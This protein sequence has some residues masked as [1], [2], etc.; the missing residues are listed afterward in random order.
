[1]LTPCADVS[2][3]CLVY[4]IE[5]ER[6]KATTMSGSEFHRELRFKARKATS[7]DYSIHPSVNT[8]HIVT[9]IAEGS[10]TC[11]VRS[12]YEYFTIP[13]N[14]QTPKSQR[15]SGSW[16]AAAASHAGLTETAVEWN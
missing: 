8:S 3:R 4:S 14:S 11:E 7:T 15:I 9:F 6:F 5:F 2:N 13:Q 10:T 1:M 16:A 12:K